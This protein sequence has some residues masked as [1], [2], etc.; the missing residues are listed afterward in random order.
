MK[1]TVIT[2]CF[3][4][5][6]TLEKTIQS[7]KEQTYSDIEYIIIDGK[8]TDT[9]IDIIKQYEKSVTRWI[10][11]PDKG[12]FDAMNKG[13]SLSTGD[14]VIFMNAGDCFAEIDVIEN[15][16][17]YIASNNEVDVYHGDIYR[18]NKSAQ[19]IWK[20]IPFYL[21]K[22]KMKGMN[23]CHQA[24]FTKLSTA[25]KY[26]FD[27][28][29]KVSAD[30]NMMMQIFNN[31]GSFKYIPLNIAIYDTTGISTTNWKQT[32]IEEARI[33]G[34]ENSPLFYLTL[35]KISIIHKIKSFNNKLK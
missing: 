20:D 27:T 11:E 21:N 18:D 26:F 33:C 2:V 34:Y 28:S 3:N 10:S 15:A 19:N 6:N 7:V 5:A 9:T 24:I 29:Y 14:Y 22:K 4:A 31:G 32:F 16:V 35:L 1:I 13:L 23:I 17:N 12:V 25:K 8:S 30:Y